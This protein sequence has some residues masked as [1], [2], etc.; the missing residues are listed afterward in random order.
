MNSSPSRPSRTSRYEAFGVFGTIFRGLD[1]KT[2]ILFLR[3]AP[4]TPNEL[5]HNPPP[6]PRPLTGLLRPRAQAGLNPDFDVMDPRSLNIVTYALCGFSNVGSVGMTLSALAGA[7]P[8]SAAPR[9][10]RQGADGAAAAA[11]APNK[12]EAVTRLALRSLL[13]GAMANFLNAALVGTLI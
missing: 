5:Y 12:I 7:R 6:R 8:A 11:I 10:P 13:A 4:K 2:P 9:A 1:R 3:A